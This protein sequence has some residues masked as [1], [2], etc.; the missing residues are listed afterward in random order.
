MIRFFLRDL[1]L[2]RRNSE[3]LQNEDGWLRVRK[4][5]SLDSR[6]RGNDSE[7]RGNDIKEWYH[8]VNS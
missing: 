6:L 4:Y 5:L 8:Y 7:R 3:I 2:P 1:G